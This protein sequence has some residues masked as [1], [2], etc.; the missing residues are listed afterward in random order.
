MSA[1]SPLDV[2]ALL[3]EA[4]APV[5]PPDDLEV[6]LERSLSTIVA[7]A[8]DTLEQW[9]PSALADPRTWVPTATALVAGAGAGAALVLVRARRRNA[10]RRHHSDNL[11]ELAERTL[12]DVATEARKLIDEPRK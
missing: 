7:D 12:R 8:A 5:E 9:E 3:R 2:E 6:R 11:L 1:A 10:R 4:L